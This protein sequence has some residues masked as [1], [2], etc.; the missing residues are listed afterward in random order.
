MDQSARLRGQKQPFEFFDIEIDPDADVFFSVKTFE[1]NPRFVNLCFI[2][3][4]RP[5]RHSALINQELNATPFPSK[6]AGV[7]QPFHERISTKFRLRRE[8]EI[9][10]KPGVLKIRLTEAVATLQN[11]RR[12]QTVFGPRKPGEQPSEHVVPLY[13]RGVYAKLLRLCVDFVLVNHSI[14]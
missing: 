6:L 5:L 12:P 9:V 10:R 1:V 7:A 2:I 14:D 3:S 4:E 8:V 11:E 13:V